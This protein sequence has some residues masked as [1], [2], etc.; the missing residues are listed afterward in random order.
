M[1][2]A[3]IEKGYRVIVADRLH[4]ENPE[5][6]YQPLNISDD[7]SL[8]KLAAWLREQSLQIDLLGIF[9]GV[10]DQGSVLKQS[11]A[12]WDLM[13]SINLASIAMVVDAILPTIAA[14]G[15]AR[16]LL[17]GSLAG[18]EPPS[19]EAGLGLYAIAKHGL[20]C[21]FRVLSD[22]LAPR[23]ITV[24]LLIPSAIEGNLARNSAELRSEMLGEELD[25]ARGAQPRERKLTKAGAACKTFAAEWIAGTRVITN[26]PTQVKERANTGANALAPSRGRDSRAFERKLAEP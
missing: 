10:I 25:A 15:R 16:I 2:E 13:L 21:Y 19:L 24:S 20:H 1:S 4:P 6:E 8:E 18:I 11:R 23:G 22:E 7:E 3:L 14:N 26:A 9:V 17:P 5:V 12:K